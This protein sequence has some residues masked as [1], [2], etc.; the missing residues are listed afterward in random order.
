MRVFRWLLVLPVAVVCGV[1]G[2][3][4]GGVALGMLGQAAADTGSAFVG[5]FVFVLS[6]AVM[7][8]RFGRRVGALTSVLVAILATLTVYLSRYSTVAEF[9]TLAPHQKT[10]V[11]LAQLL[12]AAAALTVVSALHARAGTNRPGQHA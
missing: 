12:A 5:N 8:P 2:S 1:I 4:S 10:A 3:L 6:T 9:T 11:P 7:A